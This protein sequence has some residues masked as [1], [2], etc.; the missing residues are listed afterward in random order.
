VLARRG[1]LST[2][3]LAHRKHKD[4]LQLIARAFS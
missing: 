3:T 1:Q 2:Y 4:D